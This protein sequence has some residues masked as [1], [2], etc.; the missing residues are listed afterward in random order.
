MAFKT[1]GLV[2][3][4][5]KSTGPGVSPWYGFDL[6]R[7]A[8]WKETGLFSRTPT[9]RADRT[10]SGSE[11]DATGSIGD[12]EGFYGGGKRSSTHA[13]KGVL[14]TVHK[15]EAEQEAQQ[16]GTSSVAAVASTGAGVR[17]P[18][19][20]TLSE[21]IRL[22]EDAQQ[23]F[24]EN[25][26][27]VFAEAPLDFVVLAWKKFEAE[28][29]EGPRSNTV[30]PDWRKVFRHHVKKNIFGIWHIDASGN[31]A[32]TTIGKKLDALYPKREPVG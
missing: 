17:T 27:E 12:A 24:I 9:G 25:Q 16:E 21:W 31:H 3:E 26:D 29:C 10:P 1:H 7:I 11:N 6:A 13:Q 15:Q 22:T 30:A 20:T 14:P 28:Y 32:L 4:V 23:N 5:R 18:T 8:K 19:P 2:I